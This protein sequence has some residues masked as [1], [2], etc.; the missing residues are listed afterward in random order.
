MEAG[1][2]AQ[3]TV[4]M[5]SSACH[6]MA[7]LAPMQLFAQ[8]AGERRAL[9]RALWWGDA[10]R[11]SSP[12]ACVCHLLCARACVCA[13]ACM[14]ICC[15]LLCP[16]VHTQW[17]APRLRL[18]CKQAALAQHATGP[19]APRALR[20]PSPSPSPPKRSVAYRSCVVV[21]VCAD[22][23]AEQATDPCRAH[24]RALPA[25]HTSSP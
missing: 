2:E 24:A 4:S 20:S 21:A 6:A 25:T 9:I 5:L 10:S 1:C 7:W 14:H 3:R 19:Q 11:V 23:A 12:C 16:D 15:P 18:A 17:K 13:C 8:A 22:S